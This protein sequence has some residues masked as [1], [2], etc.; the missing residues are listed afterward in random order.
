MIL[1]SCRGSR[2]HLSVK[3]AD[4]WGVVKKFQLRKAFFCSSSMINWAGYLNRS[5][6]GLVM[7]EPRY[8]EALSSANFELRRTLPNPGLP[9]RDYRSTCNE[10]APQSLDFLQ[11]SGRDYS[12][13]AND[14]RDRDPSFLFAPAQSGDRRSF[15]KENRLAFSTETSCHSYSPHYLRGCVERPKCGNETLLSPSVTGAVID[16]PRR[17]PFPADIFHLHRGILNREISKYSTVIVKMFGDFWRRVHPGN[18]ALLRIL[19][20][21]LTDDVAVPGKTLHHLQGNLESV[22]GLESGNEQLQQP[23]TFNFAVD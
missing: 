23:H 17:H 20:F 6:N 14:R 21:P 5:L 7:K 1:F 4:I 8:Y 19:H 22:V 9:V 15:P 3:T 13:P 10:A 16:D 2:V 11:G 18:C 12:F